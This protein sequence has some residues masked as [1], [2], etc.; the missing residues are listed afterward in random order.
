MKFE[1][2]SSCEST[3]VFCCEWI[4]LYVLC[5]FGFGTECRYAHKE[6]AHTQDAKAGMVR[7]YCAP[8]KLTLHSASFEILSSD[9]FPILLFF[10]LMMITI[11]IFILSCVVSFLHIS[12]S[13]ALIRYD[14]LTYNV[15]EFVEWVGDNHNV[16][17]G[18]V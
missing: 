13:S 18:W 12:S 5:R 11:K 8:L 6:H 2:S 3:L 16:V 10:C 1:V 15:I 4:V 14:N 7:M 17:V 9:S